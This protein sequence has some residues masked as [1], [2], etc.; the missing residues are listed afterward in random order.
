MID[1]MWM[2]HLGVKGVIT[3]ADT[4]KPLQNV[5]ISVVDGETGAKIPHEI[6]SNEQGDYFRLLKPGKT[7][8]V[9]ATME[10]YG[11]RSC[12]VTINGTPPKT[13][14]KV[15]NFQMKRGGQSRAS[16]DMGAM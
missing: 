13:M 7:Y 10:G 5:L 15:I 1:F 14:A 4:G 8:Q 9:T 2:T 6:T 16:C 3:D 12:E 11:S